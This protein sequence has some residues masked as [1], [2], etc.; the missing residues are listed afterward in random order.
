MWHILV[1]V[2]YPSTRQVLGY[3]TFT[4]NPLYF[5]MGG[6]DTKS[7]MPFIFLFETFAV[8]YSVP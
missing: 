6:V 8:I 5:K 7:Q 1:V 3:V 2:T 4:Q